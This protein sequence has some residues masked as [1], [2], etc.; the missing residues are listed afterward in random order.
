MPGEHLAKNKYV[1][2]SLFAKE[3]VKRRSPKRKKEIAQMLAIIK[4]KSGCVDCGGKFPY[5]LLDFDHVRGIKVSNIS[6]MLDR[7]SL[8]DIF[9]EIDKCEIVCANC[10]RNRTF[11]R[12]HNRQF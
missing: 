5:Y 6:R 9:K 8:E 12:K 2:Q 1:Q 4:E 7:H 10:H 11:H 3:K